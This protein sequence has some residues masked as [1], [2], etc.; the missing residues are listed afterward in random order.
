MPFRSGIRIACH[1]P[2]PHFMFPQWFVSERVCALSDPERHLAHLVKVGL[3]WFVFDATHLNQE[4]T[5]CVML[6]SF[7]RKRTAMDAAES[8]TLSMPGSIA[9]HLVAPGSARLRHIVT[10]LTRRLA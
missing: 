3:Q 1:P 7:V 2:M 10:E 9:M 8:A 5:G 6:G 4:G